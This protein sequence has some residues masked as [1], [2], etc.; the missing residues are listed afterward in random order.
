MGSVGL[1]FGSPTSGQGFDVNAAVNQI[2]T[3]LQ[4]TETPY[5]T[6]LSS[7]QSEDTALSSLGGL[8]S[9]LSSDISALTDPAG[10]LATKLGASS[11]TNVLALTNASSTA[12]AGSHTV[13]V[14]QLAQTSVVYSQAVATMDAFSGSISIQVGGAAA[15]TVSVDPQIIPWPVWQQRLTPRA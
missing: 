5:K 15:Q 3:N 7:L 1:S 4:G 8:L 10:V 2:V 13:A 9:T 12:T 11:D 14:S 6:Q